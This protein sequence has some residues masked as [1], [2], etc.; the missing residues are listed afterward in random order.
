MP[1]VILSLSRT[2]AEAMNIAS[3]CTTSP[4]LERVI[5]RLPG[6]IA[7]IFNSTEHPVSETDIEIWPQVL[8]PLAHTKFH[9]SLDIFTARDQE[10]E[11][12][13]IER[14]EQIKQM[15]EYP[16]A[17]FPPF[18]HYCVDIHLDIE[19]YAFGRSS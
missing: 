1:L 16:T 4:Y 2:F 11:A 17:F 9:V 14:A 19:G 10:R 13:C 7:P 5:N 15:L 8:H 18:T 12:N 3:D 6:V